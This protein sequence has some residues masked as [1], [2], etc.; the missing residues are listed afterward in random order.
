MTN[1]MI[2]IAE[3]AAATVGA[4]RLARSIYGFGVSR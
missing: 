1:T 3:F 4:K 2:R